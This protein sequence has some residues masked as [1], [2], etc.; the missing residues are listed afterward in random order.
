M[1]E[2]DENYKRIKS[3]ENE[4]L[5]LE[6]YTRSF[7]LRFGG[8][9]E[10]P[11]EVCTITIDKIISSHFKKRVPIENAHRI[12]RKGPKPRHIIVRFQAR[13]DRT[14]ILKMARSCL[15]DSDIFVT[16]DLP[17]KDLNSKKQFKGI[18][19]TA[20]EKGDRVLFKKGSLYING[21]LYKE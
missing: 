4:V 9:A 3:L 17:Y 6:R 14:D 8:I 2:V 7:N 18:M 11:E 12:G 20:Y 16:D 5:S 1:A 15:K 19:K 10:N 21:K 13:P